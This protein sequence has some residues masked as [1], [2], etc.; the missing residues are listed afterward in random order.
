MTVA[1]RPVTLA[2]VP[3]VRECVGAVAQEKRYLAVT[4][5]FSLQ[6]TAL[7]IARIIEQ[8]FVHHVADDEGQIVGWCDVAAKMGHVHA[9]VGVLGMGV[10][11][12]W[13]GRGIGTRLLRSVLDS[14]RKRFEQIELSVYA[15]NSVAHALYR[16]AG[17]VERGRWPKG[18]K[19][20][21]VH[22]DVVLMSLIFE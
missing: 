6:E 22:D 2:D 16:K 12:G 13:R 17:F 3:G 7:F 21:G 19:V 10:R 18:R 1:I 14:A 11:D 4:Q 15:T 8:G 20:D 5:P 9:H